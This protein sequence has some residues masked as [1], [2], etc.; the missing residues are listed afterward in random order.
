[1]VYAIGNSK[2]QQ[3]IVEFQEHGVVGELRSNLIGYVEKMPENVEER[4]MQKGRKKEF[5]GFEAR[6]G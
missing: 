2:A 3:G 5:K 6:H 1:M 4:N